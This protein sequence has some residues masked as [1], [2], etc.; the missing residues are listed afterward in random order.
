MEEIKSKVFETANIFKEK[1]ESSQELND[2]KIRLETL[3][4]QRTDLIIRLGEDTY[5]SY[6]RSEE[7]ELDKLDEIVLVDKEIHKALEGIRSIE[8]QIEGKHCECGSELFPE[9]K[10]CK[11][12]GRKVLEE[13]KTD[14]EDIRLCPRCETENHVDNNYC[15]SCGNKLK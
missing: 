6:R 8:R 12:C 15:I 4:R 1:F 13:R 14:K 5:T 11:E 2:L 10:F 9:D 3:E 7:I